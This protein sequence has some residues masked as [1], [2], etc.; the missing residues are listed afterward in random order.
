MA[1][2]GI[3]RMLKANISD[4]AENTHGISE[5]QVN[6]LFEA[7]RT[8][9]AHGTNSTQTSDSAYV[10]NPSNLGEMPH[11]LWF[12]TGIKASRIK[13]ASDILRDHFKMSDHEMARVERQINDMDLFKQPREMENTKNKK[14]AIQYE[15]CNIP[16]RPVSDDPDKRM[17][18]EKD[19][20]MKSDLPSVLGTD[21]GTPV[22]VNGKS[23][24]IYRFDKKI[25]ASSTACAHKGG[26]V[27]E[28]EMTVV[29]IEDANKLRC[30]QTDYPPI[31]TMAIRCPRHGWLFDLITG[32]C[33]DNS[34]CTT[35]RNLE[36]YACK[37]EG[38]DPESQTVRVGIPEDKGGLNIDKCMEEVD[39]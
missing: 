10:S 4:P 18:F 8:L 27:H 21:C 33:L 12:D 32:D 11:M 13:N 26:P 34:G 39:F 6:R 23:V 2:R 35:K 14:K 20:Q 28:G 22:V 25:C 30:G 29:D 15:G 17:S 24:M 38:V 7:T 16:D 31:R 19:A 3:P 37:V 9:R 5:E 1:G 36:L